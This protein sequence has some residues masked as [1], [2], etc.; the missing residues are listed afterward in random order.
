MEKNSKS[1]I[2]SQV[3]WNKCVLCQKPLSD[4]LRCPL[5]SM[6]NEADSWYDSLCLSIQRSHEL[7]CMPFET[8]LLTP[9]L[10]KEELSQLFREKRAKW[11]KLCR[12]QFSTLKLE[13]AQKRKAGD[14][15][16]KHNESRKKSPRRST[17]TEVR[18]G[19]FFCEETSGELHRASTFNLDRNVRESARILNDTFLLR[20]LSA[21]DMVALDAMYHTQ[22]LSKLYKRAARVKNQ[23]VIPTDNDS[24]RQSIALAELVSF[25]EE[26]RSDSDDNPVFKLSELSKMYTSRLEQMGVD[27]SQRVH[28]THL[29]ERLIQQCPE[30]TSYK[31]GWEVF[32]AF[33]EDI[34]A[35][36]KK[37]IENN[38][39][40]EEMLIAKAANIIRWDL[41]NM[42]KSKF[43]GTFEANCQEDSVPQSLRSL[44][45]MIMGGTSIETQSS[46]IVENQAAL[47]VSQLIRFNSVVRRRKDSQAIY[48]TK[49]RET[50]LP[51]YLGLLVHAETRKKSLVD[52]LCDLGL[53]ISYNRVLEISSEMGNNMGERFQAEKVVCPSNLKL[54]LFTT[55]VVNN[56][57]HNPSSTTATGSLH[58]TAISLFQHP[59]KE[60]QG[61]ERVLVQPL[62]NQPTSH[63]IAPLPGQ[64][65]EVSPVQPFKYRSVRRG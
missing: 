1:E 19:C 31:D 20:K 61:Q 29:K 45:E 57:D 44:I 5:D 4:R 27:I 7:G 63:G 22:C 3:D 46:N 28:S 52:K 11:H 62:P 21:G 42:E 60:N 64:Y 9:G 34:A 37:V 43:H 55:S 16:G 24:I 56:I 40:S 8:P 48:H 12:N 54:T 26:F 38:F 35:V 13:R 2:V 39:N 14:S 59:T 51:T 6:Q 50:P 53:S 10:E 32:L 49:D 65:A 18:Q 25:L 23:N 36:L 33:N 41:L 30:L 15:D 17:D 47:T 58:G